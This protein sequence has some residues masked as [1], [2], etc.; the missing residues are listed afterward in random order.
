ML[1]GIKQFGAHV[2][3]VN[4]AMC[5]ARPPLTESEEYLLIAAEYEGRCCACD[6]IA[7]SIRRHMC[8]LLKRMSSRHGVRGVA[9]G[10]GAHADEQRD[11]RPYRLERVQGGCHLVPAGVGPLCGAP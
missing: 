8:S 9:R 11:S 3:S 7:I 2:C 10:L 1:L 4:V 5:D 6:L